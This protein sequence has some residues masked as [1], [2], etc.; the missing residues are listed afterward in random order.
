MIVDSPEIK[1]EIPLMMSSSDVEPVKKL[2]E[3]NATE[4]VFSIE[5]SPESVSLLSKTGPT[6]STLMP[7][8]TYDHTSNNPYSFYSNKLGAVSMGSSGFYNVP[9]LS[10]VYGQFHSQVISER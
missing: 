4:K 6:I 8:Y 1:I 7:T 5:Q 3:K 2:I 10:P 9:A